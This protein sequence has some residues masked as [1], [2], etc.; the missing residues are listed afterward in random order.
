M[1]WV[2]VAFVLWTHPQDGHTIVASPS[3]AASEQECKDFASPKGE[4]ELFEIIT[5]RLD[6]RSLSGWDPLAVRISCH[7]EIG[8]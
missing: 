7:L 1:K 4:H 2:V 6:G 3:D 5:K 8:V